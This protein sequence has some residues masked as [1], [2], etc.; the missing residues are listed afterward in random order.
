MAGNIPIPTPQQQL[1]TAV[2]RLAQTI[3]DFV[4]VNPPEPDRTFLRT[5]DAL[6]HTIDRLVQN[7]PPEPDRGLDHAVDTLADTIGMLVHL[8]PPE[9]DRGAVLDTLA[10]AMDT[11]VHIDDSPPP[12]PETAMRRGIATLAGTVVS[13]ADLVLVSPGP[14]REL[15]DTIEV[16]ARDLPPSPLRDLDHILAALADTVE[17]LGVTPD[18]SR[19]GDA[20][21]QTLAH[22]VDSLVHAGNPPPDPENPPPDPDRAL[23]QSVDALT[24]TIDRFVHAGLSPPPEPDRVLDRGVH[25]LAHTIDA[26]AHAL[27]LIDPM[28]DAEHVAAIDAAVHAV[29]VALRGGPDGHADLIP[30]IDTLAR[31]VGEIIPCIE[32]APERGIELALGTLAHTLDFVAHENPPPEP[33][34]PLV[35][36]IDTLVHAVD[37]LVH[38][39]AIDGS[40]DFLLS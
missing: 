15:A 3:E 1:E 18:A 16:L 35:T 19:A 34:R 9:P 23:V 5:V 33:E 14:C 40:H 29:D 26:I 30:A 6:E 28:E 32:P 2:D 22:T 39:T 20:A 24:H 11:L 38:G 27:P 36:G 25:D 21:I 31:A 7:P 10:H 37:A 13:L 12:D 4:L 17:L 8:P